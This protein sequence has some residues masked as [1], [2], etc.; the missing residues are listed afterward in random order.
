MGARLKRN[1]NH[2]SLEVTDNGSEYRG[3]SVGYHIAHHEV[4]TRALHLGELFV[5]RLGLVYHTEINYLNAVFAYFLY[6]VGVI[7]LKVIVQ[8]RE[9]SV[10]GIVRHGKNTDFRT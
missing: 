4:K 9:L 6:E 8:S 7:F 1:E 5:C 2:R 10:I 3:G